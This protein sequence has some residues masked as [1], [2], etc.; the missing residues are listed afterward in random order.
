M[1]VSHIA[2]S[3]DN[4]IERK[5]IEKKKKSGLKA[6]P[7]LSF[8]QTKPIVSATQKRKIKNQFH[9]NGSKW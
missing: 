8:S 3:A 4:Y 9:C 1:Y 5:K 6:T 7:K 2:A